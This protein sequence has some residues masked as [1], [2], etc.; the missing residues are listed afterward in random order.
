MPVKLGGAAGTAVVSGCG[1]TFAT[2]T[3]DAWCLESSQQ[4]FLRLSSGTLASAA[5]TNQLVLYLS[6]GAGGQFPIPVVTTPIVYA[7]TDAASFIQPAA[8]QFLNVAPYE[9]LSI[10]GDNFGTFTVAQP[11]AAIVFTNGRLPASSFDTSAK[12]LTVH[13]TDSTGNDLAADSDGYLLLWTSTQINVLVPSTPPSDGVQELMATVSV[14][15]VSSPGGNVTSFNLVPASPNML[16]FGI[17]Q[18]V[19]VNGLDNSINSSTNAAKFGSTI[20]LYLS[21]MGL[22][23]AG[24]AFAG[25]TVGPLPPGFAG[26]AS[27]ASFLAA[28]TIPAVHAGLLTFDGAVIDS[29]ILGLYALPPCFDPS[30]VSVKIGNITLAT[31]VT[32]AGFTADTIAGLYQVNVAVPLSNNASLAT[33]TPPADSSRNAIPSAGIDWWREQ[34]AR[35]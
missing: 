22:P 1:A 5:G 20:V 35:G 21:G 3:T 33:L 15:G 27:P 8:G 26:C 16:N 32:Y 17:G 10:F 9:M 23:S 28:W 29:T 25:N 24:T 4:F 13:F 2:G 30:T 31:A 12:P 19:V 11:E 6:A 14:A 18:G 34:P 7:V